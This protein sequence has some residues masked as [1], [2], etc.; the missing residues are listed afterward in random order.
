[1]ELTLLSL[2]LSGLGAILLGIAVL[3]AACWCDRAAR[4]VGQ[5]PAVFDALGR[6][7]V[8]RDGLLTCSIGVFSP[9]GI[10]LWWVCLVVLVGVLAR[11]LVARHYA[12]LWVMTVAAERM[13]PLVPVLDAFARECGG[14]FGRRVRRLAEMLSAGMPLPE[15]ISRQRRLFPPHTLPIL[16]VGCES[17]AL[18]AALRRAASAQDARKRLWLPLGNGLAYAGSVVMFGMGVVFFVMLKIVPS[19]QKIFQDFDAELPAMTQALIQVSDFCA[20]YWFLF[21]WLPLLFFAALLY[22]T[23]GY[24][25]GVELGTF[26]FA[27][28]TRRLDA[29]TILESLAMAAEQ[30]RPLPET[31]ARMAQSYPS[32]SIRGRLRAVSQDLDAGVDWCESLFARGLIPRAD[33]AVLQA[34]ARVGNLPWAMREMADSNRRRFAYRLDALMQVLFPPLVVALGMLV[35]FFVISL[36]M[37]LISLIQKLV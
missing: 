6:R 11:R 5:R 28:L 37:P 17:G 24:G 16:Q 21:A 30:R 7:W 18:A 34:A 33:R 20:N 3:A 1:M 2:F 22:V 36:F 25:F 13:I 4:S 19:F 12:L 10:L 29:A 14:S 15:A 27:R 23:L 8:L 9:A 35:A 32:M 26:G 31:V